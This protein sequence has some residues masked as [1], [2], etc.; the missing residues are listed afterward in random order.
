MPKALLIIPPCFTNPEHDFE[1]GFPVNLLLLGAQARAVGWDIAYL[2][3]TLEEKEGRDSFAE[4][5]ALLRDPAVEAAGVSNHTIRTSVTT[6]RVAEHIKA[7]RPD[8]KVIAGGVNATFMYRQLLEWSPAIDVVLRGYA[9][10]GF[11]ALLASG[12]EP[13]PGQVPGL[14]MRR[15]GGLHVEPLS[16]VVPE[17]FDM[18]EFDA[19]HVERYLDWTRTYPLLTHTGCGFA[20]NFCTSVMPGP[21]QSKEVYR[22]V[23]RVVG[24]MRRAAAAGFERFFMTANVFTSDRDYCLRLCAALKGEPSLGRAVWSCMTRVE[25]VDE[26][27]L[28]LMR[29]AGCDNVAFGVETAGRE[30]WRSLRKGRF[31]EETVFEAFGLTSRAGV[32]TTAYLMLGAPEQTHADVEATIDLVC[33]LDPDYRVVSFFQPF[34]GTPYWE[35]PERFGLTEIAPLEDWNFH[36][37]PVCRTRHMDKQSLDDAAVKLYLCRAGQHRLDLDAV[38]LELTGEA[39]PAGEMPRAAFDAFAGI[40]SCD[41]LSAALRDGLLRMAGES[42]A[43]VC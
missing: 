35:D 22:P 3:M 32:G 37:G 8:V 19:A 11:R 15:G 26:E 2:D 21:Y 24:E 13:G 42:G 27:L 40:Y 16:P 39:A 34:P 29:D 5:E 18:P 41:W 17:D 20:C 12:C 28:G 7:S 9:Q 25:F 43:E 36:E 23:E 4:L 30:Q 14:V 1:V 10:A 31:S 6:K 33:E 38:A